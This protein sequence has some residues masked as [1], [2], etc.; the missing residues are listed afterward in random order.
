MKKTCIGLLIFFISS[1]LLPKDNI[2]IGA[3]AGYFSVRDNTIKQV[4]TDGDVTYGARIGVRIWNGLHIWLSGG[5]FRK[6]SGTT[7][8]GDTTTLV[9][10]PVTLSLRYAA[11]LGRVNP[12]IGGG[13]TYIYYKE[14][15]EI[16]NVTGEGKGYSVDAGIEIKLAR[17]F[18]LDL[19]ASYSSAKVNP[20]GFDI[21]LGGLQTCV[22]FL[23]VI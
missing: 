8:L 7:L 11:P 22:S 23:L 20:T 14:K 16:G 3:Y 19:G 5:Q 21:E 6:V 9:L 17:W 1:F 4:Y 18:S 12:Y 10:N 2:K 13:Y 15:S